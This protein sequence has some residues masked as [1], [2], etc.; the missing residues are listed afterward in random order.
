MAAAW[1]WMRSRL[2]NRADSEH[3][4]V[5]VRI[6]ITALFASYLGWEVGG[7]DLR[8]ALVA[9]WLI[10]L[11]ELGLSLGLLAAILVDPRP[12]DPRRWLGMVADYAAMGGV[13]YLQGESAA[14]L[15]AVY[16]WVTVGNGMRYGPRYL[17]VATGMAAASFLAMMRATP[18]WLENPYLSWGLLLGLVAVPLYFASLLK[19]LTAAIEDA[20]RANLAKSRFLAN[21]S[22]EFRTPLNGLS[23]MSEL[24]ASTRLDAEQRGYL[25]T[26]QASARALLALVEDVLDISAIEAG[27][28]KLKVES[29]ELRALVD[30]IDLMLRPEARA[31]QLD[32]LVA[33]AADVPARLR[34]DPGH[35]RQV[36]VNLLSNAIKFTPAGQVRLEVATAGGA[37]GG[38]QRLRFTVTD[39][40][41]GIPASARAKL[42]EA[43][44]QAD[45]SLVR[46]H[47][48]TGLGTTIAKGLTEAMGG[49]IGFESN[50][51]AGSRFWVEL[52]F[53]LDA[54]PTAA[55]AAPAAQ[56]ATAAQPQPPY[57]G[58][59][60]IA[61]SDPFLRHRARV[62]PLRALIADDHSANRMV[63]QGVLQKAG[64]RVLAVEDGE[65]AL[66]ALAAGDFDLAIVD[67][68]MPGLS[69]ID[70]LR[71][72]RVM[73]A[74]GSARTP[75]IVLSAD[76]TPDSVQACRQAGAKAFIPKPF[77]AGKLLD[78]V[79][80]IATGGSVAEVDPRPAPQAAPAQD[81]LDPAVLDELASLGMGS[82]FEADFIGQCVADARRALGLMRQAGADADWDAYR[83]QAHALKGIAGNLGLVQ[84]AA[85]SGKLM[86]TT[87][88]E[89]V[90]DWRRHCDA[91]V[92]RMSAGEQALAARGSWQPAREDSR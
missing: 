15:Y 10:L 60:V 51:N 64:H 13:M 41:I 1:A 4:Q 14:P 81:L 43:F 6:A 18:Y 84:L 12:S 66:D 75:V 30:E 45:N 27:K 57:D 53:Q 7:G 68:H 48:G 72:L 9:T 63:L 32:Y 33:I 49:L 56:A 20:R 67:L 36:L 71:Q 35:L 50:E 22:H 85:H 17:F 62:R 69:G 24:L 11:G 31:K 40:G 70:L 39:T 80:E 28:L 89:L 3:G 37:A 83:E 2:R 23:G 21:M 82:A 78:A 92:E 42:F 77:Q 54:V 34:G 46:R 25:E 47:A 79:A 8:P 44:E 58:R 87:G 91:L 59:K 73:E 52:P 38:T 86:H 76:A 55:P 16:L 74:G 26:I 88:F 19:A 90:R 65:S 61:F 5:F 29:F